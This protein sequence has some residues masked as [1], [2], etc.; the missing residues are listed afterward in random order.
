MGKWPFFKF[1]MIYT[2]FSLSTLFMFT[3]GFK[4]IVLGEIFSFWMFSFAALVLS[5]LI[6]CSATNAFPPR[7]EVVNISVLYWSFRSCIFIGEICNQPVTSSVCFSFF[8]LLIVEVHFLEYFFS[9]VHR[10]NIHLW[11]IK[12]NQQ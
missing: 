12:I 1:F 10:L 4:V 11:I 5:S 7:I 9:G 6:F 2:Y 3:V 8:L